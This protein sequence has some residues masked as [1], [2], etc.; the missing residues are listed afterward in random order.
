[1][2]N[3]SVSRSARTVLACCLLLS[4]MLL[5]G[6]WDEV[7]LQDQTYVSSLGVELKDGKFQLYAQMIKFAGVAKVE[8]SS[9]PVGNQVWIGKGTGSTVLLAINHLKKGSQSEINLE[10]LK[11]IVVHESAMSRLSDIMDGLN[12]LRAS[13]YTSLVF[14]TK[15]DIVEIFTAEAL[16]EQSPLNTMLFLPKVQEIQ[17]SFIGPFPMKQAVQMLKEPGMTTPVPVIGMNGSDWLKGKKALQVQEIDGIF[18][19]KKS[20]YIGFLTEKEAS[21]LRWLNPNFSLF[22]VEAKGARGKATIAIRGASHK[23]TATHGQG[24]GDPVFKLSV[25]LNGSVVEQDQ[26]INKEEIVNSIA[27]SI[28]EDLERTYATGREKGMDLYQLEHHMYRYHNAEWKKKMAGGDWVPRLDQLKIDVKFK[29][30]HSGKF[31]LGEGT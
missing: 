8:G 26:P 24:S 15:S 29:L 19:L 27:A 18:V 20:K 22:M 9:S 13:R 10:H 28:K 11:S 23:L 17:R 21:G 2:K 6:C 16:F 25:Q 31:D 1:M 30:I 5:Q 7:N 4:A 14:G 3:H 12:R